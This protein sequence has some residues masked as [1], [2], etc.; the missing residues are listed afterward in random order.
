V[1]LAVGAKILLACCRECYGGKY[2]TSLVRTDENDENKDR[3]DE[4]NTYPQ[5]ERYKQDPHK[6]NDFIKVIGY[7]TIVM[8]VIA[9]IGTCVALSFFLI[10]AK[11]LERDS[12]VP[13]EQYNHNLDRLRKY[14]GN[15]GSLPRRVEDPVSTRG[16]H[17]DPFGN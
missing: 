12:N 17:S 14:T 4:V 6:C 2:A 10:D 9:L 8:S 5:R 15:Y 7:F 1:S 16:Q 3:R 11:R 13:V